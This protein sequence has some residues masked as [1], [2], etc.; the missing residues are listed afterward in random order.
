MLQ[1][2]AALVMPLPAPQ[3]LVNELQ[4]SRPGPNPSA[5]P[6][7]LSARTRLDE[8]S[9]STEYTARRREAARPRG[10][11]VPGHRGQRRRLRSPP[12]FHRGA[13]GG[14]RPHFRPNLADGFG[15]D[16]RTEPHDE[17]SRVRASGSMDTS[18]ADMGRLAA[19]YVRG[20]GLSAA[21]R[22]ELVRPQLPITTRTQFPTLQ[23]PRTPSPFPAIGAGLGVIAFTGPQGAG[24]FKGGHDDFTANTWVCVEAGQRC[25]VILAND[26]RAEPAFPA[27]VASILGE[28]GVPWRWEYGAMAFWQA[29]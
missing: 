11:A 16:G 19:S 26:V 8:C 7:R 14:P 23:E 6:G 13:G 25:V 29:R 5:V 24:F 10:G 15:I 1:R 22:A 21:A 27:L 17:R 4:A 18:I 3:P 12:A 2:Q 9:G 28:T 20:D